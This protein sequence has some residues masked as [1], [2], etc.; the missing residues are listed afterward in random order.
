AW[1]PKWEGTTPQTAQG[2][3]DPA[4][5]EPVILKPAR[6]LVAHSSA[7]TALAFSPDGR[8]MASGSWDRNIILWSTTDWKPRGLLRGHT[9]QVM[10]LAFS[11][12]S[13]QLASTS[14][15][16]DTCAIRLWNL[17]NGTAAGTLGDAWDGLFAVAWLPGGKSLISAG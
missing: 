15:D 5:A 10:G 1:F 7:V 14:L 17:A 2:Q 13:R 9:S 12:D 8:V 6:G 11:P 16:K 4:P 3:G